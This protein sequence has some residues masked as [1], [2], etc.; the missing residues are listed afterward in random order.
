[1]TSKENL[2][3]L[4]KALNKAAILEQKHTDAVRNAELVFLEVFGED[5]PEENLTME[6]NTGK[7]EVG[8][9]FNNFVNHGENMAG[10]TIKE[11]VQKINELM[12]NGE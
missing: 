1:M 2:K 10:N 3:R 8:S 9:L 11:L 12:E 6:G 7:E 4:M 5:I